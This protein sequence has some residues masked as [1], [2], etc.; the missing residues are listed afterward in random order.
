MR[1][2]VTTA[3]RFSGL[4]AL[5]FALAGCL[6]S[7]VERSGGIGSV[8]VSNSNPSAII[9]SAQNIFVRS[10]YRMTQVRFPHSVTFEKPSGQFANMMWGSFSR[11]QTVRAKLQIGEIPGTADF[12][13]SVRLFSV[14]SA[15]VRGFED[16]RQ[17]S[18]LWA[19]EFRPMLGR[20]ARQAD[21][22]GRQ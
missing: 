7:P 18:G 2:A 4:G 15:G 16:A 3:L 21:N 5:A 11:P 17:I 8:T 12:R 19:M 14:T 22:A 6:V 13:I 20:I 10:G 9:T 1:T